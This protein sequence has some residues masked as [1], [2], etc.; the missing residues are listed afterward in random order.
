MTSILEKLRIITLSNVHSV[1]DAVI[2]LNDV[3][4]LKVYARDLEGA[5][6]QMEQ[7]D[8]GLQGSIDTLL[9]DI[10]K[11]QRLAD[12][13]QLDID[14]LLTDADPSNDPQALKIQVDLDATTEDL[15]GMKEKLAQ[16]KADHENATKVIG[17]LNAKL[18]Q[19]VRRI[20]ELEEAEKETAADH[21]A[22]QT[23][24]NVSR[25]F[26]DQPSVDSVGQKIM[27]KNAEAR[28]ELNR[29]MGKAT[30]V[31]MD[32]TRIA[33]AA[34]ALARRKAELA[35]QQTHA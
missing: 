23:M 11:S 4:A 12:G 14:T 1:L 3:G 31:T 34:A 5:V 20:K 26:G 15:V 28:A 9:K 30:D 6:R 35:G 33:S 25:A 24:E 21:Q 22:A 18:T 10:G 32:D 17:A 8:N 7:L 16:K 13:W 29:A 2:N 27:A 19:T